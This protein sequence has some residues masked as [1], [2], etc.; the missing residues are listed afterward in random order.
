[1]RAS[2]STCSIGGPGLDWR[3][4]RR[5]GPNHPAA[6]EHVDVLHAHQ[7]A[8]FFYS[9]ASRLVGWRPPILFSEHGR[10]Q[11]DYPR[12]KRILANRVLLRR[13]DRVAAVGEAVRQALIH[14]EG[15]SPR[16]VEVIYNGIP[17]EQFGTRLTPTDRAAV[18]AEIGLEVEDF[19]L[20]M[21]ARLDYLKDH[22]TAIRTIEAVAGRCP[23]AR[24]I[25]VGE[26]PEREAIESLVTQ[27]D[28][29]EYVRLLGQRGDVSRLMAASDV[30]LL[31]SISEGIPL[32]LI[33]AM[34]S[35]LP[36]VSTQVG[37]VAEVVADGETGLLAPSGDAAA[38][39]EHICCLADDP[40][41]RD[42]MGRAGRQRAEERFS[43]RRMHDAY[44]HIYEELAGIRGR[45]RRDRSALNAG[46][47]QECR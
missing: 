38:L 7:Y 1:M 44:A 23:R 19:A 35:G 30:V 14:N 13:H 37:G 17:L 40:G 12:R 39:A 43:E 16:R 41:R 21:V 24:L 34:A 36:V 9:A 6:R 29:G 18:R 46:R 2:R 32:T 5:L 10:H 27:R 15:L 31:T 3:C 28:L 11:P 25:L 20:L 42:K 45:N 47:D 8:P 33:E 22:A 26:G 4:P